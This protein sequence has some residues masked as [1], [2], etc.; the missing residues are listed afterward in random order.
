MVGDLLGKVIKF[1][2]DFTLNLG[3]KVLEPFYITRL[4]YFY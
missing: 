1:A 2:F 3:F 4:H